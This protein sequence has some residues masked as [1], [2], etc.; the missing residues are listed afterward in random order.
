MAITMRPEELKEI[1]GVA[2]MAATT[3]LL[4][5]IDAVALPVGARVRKGNS[6][7]A[8]VLED[9]GFDFIEESLSMGSVDEENVIDKRKFTT[10]FMCQV[11]EITLALKHIHFGASI[12]CVGGTPEVSEIESV[13]KAVY[14]IRKDIRRLKKMS[15]DELGEFADNCGVPIDL[16]IKVRDDGK[17]PALLYAAGQIVNPADAALLINLGCDGI[18]IGQQIIFSDIPTKRIKAM[19]QAVK[20]HTNDELI[21]DLMYDFENIGS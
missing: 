20:N 15:E 21:A 6:T 2:R 10:P 17:L 11:E 13:A 5:F 16:V 3:N 4:P 14:G 18:C 19:V 1:Y 12:V 9:E 7:E 8:A